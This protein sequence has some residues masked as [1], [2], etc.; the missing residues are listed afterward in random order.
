MMHLIWRVVGAFVLMRF[1]G[2][3]LGRGM[4]RGSILRSIPWVMNRSLTR[5]PFLRQVMEAV[6]ALALSRTRM[7]RA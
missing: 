4:R 7:R 6:G 3:L 2:P 5:N 1:L